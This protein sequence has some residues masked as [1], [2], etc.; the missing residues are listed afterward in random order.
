MS[1]GGGFS[2]D[3]LAAK[4]DDLRAGRE[5][6]LRYVV[7]FSGGI[8]STVL[9]HAL[10]RGAARDIPL[11]AVHVDHQLQANSTA[12]AQ[13]CAAFATSLG[14]PFVSETVHVDLSAGRG[15]EAAARDAR[16]TALERCLDTGDWLLSAHHCDDQA[17]TLLLNL[18]R[19]SGPAG[20]A[21]MQSVRE[22]GNSL[23]VRPLLGIEKA[24]LENYARAEELEWIADPSNEERDFD[25]NFLRNAVLPVLQQRWPD[26]NSRLSHSAGLARDSTL[27]L[28]ELADQDLA[29]PALQASI[30]SGAA[31]L[32]A[33][34]LLNLSPSRARNLLRRL[35]DRCGLA[36]APA[37]RLDNILEELLPARGDAE[38]CV[39]WRGGCVRRYRDTVYFL[40]GEVQAEFTG[41]TL[42]PAH[43]VR[44]GTGFGKLRLVRGEGVGIRPAVAEAGLSLRIR[45][46]G[47]QIKPVGQS[48]TRKLKKLLQEEGVLPWMRDHLPLLY[49]G[50]DL[51]A[52]ADLWLAAAF[53]SDTGYQV[54]WEGKPAL[55]Q[56]ED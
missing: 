3:R 27:L 15:P 12:W 43:A 18:L 20:V 22:L 47:E 17:E 36:A 16:Y 52:V 50:D 38:P 35:L 31:T 1:A 48:H 49:S 13:H 39:T 55:I 34:G 24:S 8:D 10:V 32:S 56:P 21:A 53:A 30:E 45:K 6:P 4:L 28:A 33:R 25:R 51:I 41:T 19:G 54:E 7:A 37:T 9:L 40:A 29:A 44:L 5:P 23:L 26:A 2:P 14:V 11:L 46:G 42:T